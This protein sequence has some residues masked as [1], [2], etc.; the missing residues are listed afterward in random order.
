MGLGLSLFTKEPFPDSAPEPALP[1]LYIENKWDSE[2]PTSICAIA[3][4]LPANS[5]AQNG[6][7]INRPDLEHCST[8]S[9]TIF[10]FSRISTGGNR[11]QVLVL[12]AGFQPN[13]LIR[14]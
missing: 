9:E 6:R 1:N 7:K 11:S 14:E 5:Q 2:L 10:P 3:G 12:R 8:I 4:G 13:I